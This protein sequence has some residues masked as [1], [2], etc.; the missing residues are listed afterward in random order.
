MPKATAF[1]AD[2]TSHSLQNIPSGANPNA[3]QARFKQL[4]PTKKIVYMH[5][6]TPMTSDDMRV[7]GQAVARARNVAPPPTYAPLS[8]LEGFAARVGGFAGGM[9]QGFMHTIASGEDLVGYGADKL[10]A[11]DIGNAFHKGATN[12]RTF[13][14]KPM[15]IA[16]QAY[17]YTTAAGNVAGNTLATSLA[18]G[19]VGRALGAAG[20][21]AAT[22]SNAI[23]RGAAPVVSRLGAAV[24]SGGV[25]TGVKVTTRLG[26]LAAIPYRVVGGAA[27][28][29]ANAMGDKPAD[30]GGTQDYASSMGVGALTPVLGVPAAKV[31][32]GPTKAILEKLLGSYPV[33]K[34]G[35]ILREALGDQL[36]AARIALENAKP[37][38]TATQ[39]LQRHGI[40]APSLA[41][42]FK[43]TSDG[44][45]DNWMYHFHNKEYENNLGLLQQAGGG[46]TGTEQD[47]AARQARVDLNTATTPVREQAM[48]DASVGNTQFPPL[49]AAIADAATEAADKTAL[50]KRMGAYSEK[51]AAQSQDPSLGMEEMNRMRGLSGKADAISADAAN[52]SVHAGE[53]QQM[54]TQAL[55][56][57]KTAGYGEI[58]GSELGDRLMDIANRDDIAA[59]APA[60][61][62]LN[63]MAN[64][65]Q[66][67]TD[68]NGNVSPEVLHS[69]T[70]NIGTRM[71]TLMQGADPNVIQRQAAAMAGKITPLMNDAIDNAGAKAPWAEFRSRFG[72]GMDKINTARM[73]ADLSQ[74]YK[75][76]DQTGVAKVLLGNNTPYV[77]NF[78][79]PKRNNLAEELPTDLWNTSKS[80]ANNIV[81]NQKISEQEA[82]GMPSARSIIND[83]STQSP[84]NWV[85]LLSLKY[86]HV[87]ARVPL[88]PTSG[89]SPEI[90]GA[91]NTA[92]KN[93]VHAH[94]MLS[95]LPVDQRDAVARMIYHPPDAAGVA[96][97]QAS[98]NE[99]SAKDAPE[100][101]DDQ[102]IEN[103]DTAAKYHYLSD[104]FTDQHNA[105]L[106]EQDAVSNVEPAPENAQ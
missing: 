84:L 28:G 75:D 87:G 4:F 59:N 78:L 52:A 63:D 39:A 45:V 36:T 62:V 24:S 94:D 34:G 98:T 27:A 90:I 15:A 93:G 32:G 65:I 43:L 103:P 17:P 104:K 106:T 50:A 79:G 92:A 85:R 101:Y 3:I 82:A 9:G 40:D 54:H 22:S 10:G 33:V 38:E 44:S 47:A 7:A 31:L 2:G 25:N 5:G 73:F 21:A 53:L 67:K 26:G 89:L 41:A 71:Q 1:F 105:P 23:V 70:K 6:D 14:D 42:V 55:Q 57:M 88:G 13:V 49:R 102:Y 51:A 72:E 18:L 60:R 99:L 83:A 30:Q 77:E 35:Q 96:M 37:G 69:I 11:K 74:K 19:P 46:T 12:T 81:A 76:G 66:W 58:R 8:G 80:I 61:T 95:M 64:V 97:T 16:T 48:R 20:G 91:I 100:T 56:D 68:E 86:G 29:V